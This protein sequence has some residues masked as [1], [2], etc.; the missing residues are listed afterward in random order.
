M[1]EVRYQYQISFEIYDNRQI[2]NSRVI[3]VGIKK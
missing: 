2:G 3:D 1:I